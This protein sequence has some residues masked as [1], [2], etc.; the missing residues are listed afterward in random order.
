MF[1]IIKAAI[2]SGNY[3]LTEM[4]VKIHRMYIFGAL[5][6]EQMEQLLN[7]ASGGVNADAERP[8]VLAMLQ[9]LAER[10][11]AIEK[12]MKVE[13]NPAEYEAW[14]PW[15]GIS[16]KY[17]HGAIVSHNGKLWIS[18]FHG[19]NVWEPGTAGTETLWSEY[20]E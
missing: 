8:D 10:I 1:E 5:T 6:E 15:D 9:S 13:E 11:E 16:N 18:V 14:K 3:K 20:H 19:Q 2:A 7:M 12:Q 17:Q 4:Q